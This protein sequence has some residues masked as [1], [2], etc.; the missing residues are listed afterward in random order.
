MK[1]LTRNFESTINS[2]NFFQAEVIL[3][4]SGMKTFSRSTLNY[5]TE[6][7]T[8]LNHNCCTKLSREFSHKNFI[9]NMFMMRINMNYLGP[10][11]NNNNIVKCSYGCH[12]W[13]NY[14]I[15]LCIGHKRV[16]LCWNLQPADVRQ[17]LQNFDE[18]FTCAFWVYEWMNECGCIKI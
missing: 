15:S 7:T 14:K 18:I 17:I 11:W 16:M 2:F 12:F 8:N 9:K 3:F 6:W 10:E 5:R 1:W 13:I 4:S